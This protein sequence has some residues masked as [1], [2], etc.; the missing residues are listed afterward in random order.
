MPLPAAQTLRDKFLGQLA[1][2][3]T[4][5][6]RATLEEVE[7]DL[8]GAHP[9]MRLIQGDVGC[10]KTVVAAAAALAAVAAGHQVAVMAPTELLAEQHAKNFQ[11][12]FEPLGVEVARL[13]GKQGARSR[14]AP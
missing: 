14:E 5:D 10:G 8:A 2:D 13:S 4:R 12:W 3:L 6:Q 1:F 7:S 11:R 9:M